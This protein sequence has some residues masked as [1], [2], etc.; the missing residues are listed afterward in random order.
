MYVRD[1]Q[2]GTDFLR[3][4]KP[5]QVVPTTCISTTMRDISAI[6]IIRCYHKAGPGVRHEACWG[7]KRPKVPLLVFLEARDSRNQGNYASLLTIKV[8][9]LPFVCS[10]THWVCKAKLPF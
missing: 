8:R 10:R 4:E 2:S 5:E 6:D 1:S 3:D 7:A 9:F